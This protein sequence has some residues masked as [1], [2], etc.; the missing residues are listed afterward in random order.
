M[1][2]HCAVTFSHTVIW[3]IET[4]LIMKI[5]TYYR[6]S[7]KEQGRSGLGLEAQRETVARYLDTLSAVNVVAEFTDVMSG[8][9]NDRPEL[10]KA[11]KRCRLT[12]ASLIVAKLDR[13]SR[14]VEFIAQLQKSGVVF[15]CA[16]MPQAC[17]LTISLLAALAEHE[18]EMISTRTRDALQAAKRR[19][20]VLGNPRL[21]DVANVD[22]T[23]ARRVHV[24]NAAERNSEL[25]GIIADIED[26][27]GEP[28]SLQQI[29]D[30]LNDAG[31]T[32]TR[33]NAFTKTAVMRI[34]RLMVERDAA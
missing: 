14:D 27:A 23:K 20:V 26:E 12:G 29:A 4:G 24:A 5:V 32:T 6:V 9:K 16:N 10:R 33:G 15:T 7:T 25:G 1:P 30:E 34:K 2:F 17:N 13:L 19:G 3:N 18:R 22:T 11:L 31:Y 28:L 21:A 8:G